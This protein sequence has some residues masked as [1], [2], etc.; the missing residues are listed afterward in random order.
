[1]PFLLCAGTAAPC[2]EELALRWNGR[3]VLRRYGSSLEPPLRRLSGSN[4]PQ[5]HIGVALKL[6]LQEASVPWRGTLSPLI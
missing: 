3:R 1:M 4:R 6:E 5:Q 2:R